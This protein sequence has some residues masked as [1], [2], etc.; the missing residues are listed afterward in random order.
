MPEMLQTLVL[1]DPI[2]SKV[3]NVVVI[4]VFV[5]GEKRRL[6]QRCMVKPLKQKMW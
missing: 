3:R 2:S 1:A 5:S 4:V 6:V